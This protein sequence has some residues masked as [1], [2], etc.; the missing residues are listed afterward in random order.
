[1]MNDGILIFELAIA[2]VILLAYVSIK[3]KWK[4]IEWF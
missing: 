3:K 1:M 2:I 4:I